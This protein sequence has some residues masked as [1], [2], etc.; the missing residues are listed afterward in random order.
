[1]PILSLTLGF[2][3]NLIVKTEESEIIV[4]VCILPKEF[5]VTDTITTIAGNLTCPE[6]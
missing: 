2:A 6:S 3:V 5:L 4:M 1:M